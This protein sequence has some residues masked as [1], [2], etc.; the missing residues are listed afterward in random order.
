MNKVLPVFI[1]AYSL[2][3]G[4]QSAEPQVTDKEKQRMVDVATVDIG[5]T[6]RAAAQQESNVT[7]SKKL[8]SMSTPDKNQFLKDINTKM[9]NPENPSGVFG[10]AEMQKVNV[11][12]SQG[13]PTQVANLPMAA[14]QAYSS[15]SVQFK[16]PPDSNMP[17]FAVDAHRMRPRRPS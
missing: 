11:E 2:A 5:Y 12:A 17:A 14:Y 8:S 3:V 13:K 16:L 9:V 10:M 15:D 4:A 6:R 7:A 1:A